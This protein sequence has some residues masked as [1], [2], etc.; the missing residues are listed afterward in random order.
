MLTNDKLFRNN[1]CSAIQTRTERKKFYLTKFEMIIC[2]N[3]I[4]PVF[5]NIIN[6]LQLNINYIINVFPI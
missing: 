4:S 3:P 2:P 1:V 6:K 5:Y